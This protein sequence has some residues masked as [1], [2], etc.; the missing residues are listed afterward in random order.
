[1]QCDRALPACERGGTLSVDGALALA[2]RPGGWFASCP[3]TPD[4][5]RTVGWAAGP[6]PRARRDLVYAARMEGERAL[7]GHEINAR[8]GDAFAAAGL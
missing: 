6:A 3:S 4:G 7:P 2:G 8:L 1:M 5:A